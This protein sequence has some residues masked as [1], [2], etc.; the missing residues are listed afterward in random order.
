M[1]LQREL[2]GAAQLPLVERL[3][4]VAVRRG[5]GGAPH[6][7]LVGVRGEEDHRD[8]EAFANLGGGLDAVHRSA[9]ADVHQHEIGSGVRDG[10]DRRG[11]RVDDRGHLVAEA[12]ER[13][14]DVHRHDGL[15][16]DH[17]DARVT[18]ARRAPSG[19]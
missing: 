18:H 1:A 11:A 15:V 4:H 19:S 12:A 17:D 2:D 3:E 8:V 6:G 10:A 9:E 14:G 16:L 7:R 13:R 5:R